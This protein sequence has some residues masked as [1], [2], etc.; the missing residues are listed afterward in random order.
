M[1]LQRVRSGSYIYTVI[2]AESIKR[3]RKSYTREQ[4]LDVLRWFSLNGQN[5]YCTCQQ[6]SLNTKTLPRWVKD[7]S[8]IYNSKK[9]RKRVQF[10]RTAEHPDMEEMLYE[11]YKGLRRCGLKVKGWWFKV[12]GEQLRT[13]INVPSTR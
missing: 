6:F 13:S 1:K 3:T 2:M 11:E 10:Q 9:G 5:L 12:R 7:H 8:A 4:K